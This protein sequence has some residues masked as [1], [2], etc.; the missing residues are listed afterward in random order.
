MQARSK[1]EMSEDQVESVSN[2]H[3]MGTFNRGLSEDSPP[4]YSTATADEIVADDTLP[5]NS[6]SGTDGILLAPAFNPFLGMK[7]VE[8]KG[9]FDNFGVI[10]MPM[11]LVI[12]KKSLV[13]TMS[14]LYATLLIVTCVVFVS[15]EVITI[16]VPVDYFE[17][18]GFYT[19]LYSG[20]IVFMCYIFF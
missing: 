17:S 15:T 20:S 6:I 4:A 8:H 3:A 1:L 9:I 10:D 5:R 11:N 2:I 18:K 16:N 19:Y 12:A 7:R 14:A 13:S